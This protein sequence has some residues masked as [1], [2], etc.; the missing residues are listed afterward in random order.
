MRHAKQVLLLVAGLLFGWS[1]VAA[2]TGTGTDPLVLLAEDD[3]YPYAA[4]VDGEPRGISVDLVRAAYAAVG[5]EV[6]FRIASYARCMELVNQGKY[7]GCFNTPVGE[8]ALENQ[9]LPEEALDRNPAWV[10]KRADNEADIDELADLHGEPIGIV[11]GYRY[12]DHFMN[13]PRLVREPAGSDLQN[14]KK[15]AAGRLEY[16]VLYERVAE[17]LVG[18]YGERMDLDVEPVVQVGEL[19]LY[20]S[21]SRQHPR[22]QEAMAKFDEGLRRLKQSGEYARIMAEWERKLSSGE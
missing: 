8:S 16:V 22:A 21:F 18:Q 1:T 10:Y 20:V 5:V 14:L 15:L 17:W 7:V 19:A 4:A 13:D 11:N 2:E 3:W 9:L 12:A 6:E